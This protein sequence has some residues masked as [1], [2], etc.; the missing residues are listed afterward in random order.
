MSHLHD[1][2]M[3]NQE[4]RRRQKLQQ[5]ANHGDRAAPAPQPVPEIGVWDGIHRDYTP[6]ERLDIYDSIFDLSILS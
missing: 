1:R 2:L 4:Q 6:E 5:V 3:S